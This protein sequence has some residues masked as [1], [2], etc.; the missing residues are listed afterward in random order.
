MLKSKYYYFSDFQ[1]SLA[2]LKKAELSG[3]SFSLLISWKDFRIS[4]C[5]L[6]KFVYSGSAKNSMR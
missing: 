2:L 3:V 4:V 6:F 1:N 5:F